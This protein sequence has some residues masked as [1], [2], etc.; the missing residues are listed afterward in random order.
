MPV[1]S[2]LIWSLRRL[3]RERM[4]PTASDDPSSREPNRGLRTGPQ[5]GRFRETYGA[6]GAD[7]RTSGGDAIAEMSASNARNSRIS[8]STTTLI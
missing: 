4:S 7:G 3:L 2:L 5:L 1:L 8:S 6:V